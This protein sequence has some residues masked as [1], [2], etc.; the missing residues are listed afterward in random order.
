ML[1]PAEF[2]MI[3]ARSSNESLNMM[4]ITLKKL[5]MVYKHDC[6]TCNLQ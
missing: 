1:V 6:L 5:G 3:Q 4:S 2:G